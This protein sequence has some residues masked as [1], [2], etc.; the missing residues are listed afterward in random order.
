MTNESR[1]LVLKQDILDGLKTL[2][3]TKGS[4]VMVHT[5]LKNMG[6][7]CGGAQ[8]VIESLLETVGPEGTIVMPTQTW[9]NLD[10]ETGVHW[11]EPKEW[12]PII[13]ENWPAYDKR[14]TPTNTMGKV[15]EMFRSWPGAYRSDHP[16]RSVAAVGKYANYITE[17]H[18]L[19][20]IF[21]EGSPL[22]KIYKLNGKV[23]LIG[24]GYDK[25]TSIHLADAKAE[26]ESKHNV[27]ESSAIMINGK[28]E[29]VTYETLFVDG[30]DFNEIGA[31][32]EKECKVN[33][34]NIGNALVR[35]MSQRE[36]VDYSVKWIEKNR[37]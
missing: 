34:T 13:R 15:A 18:D 25:N 9:K 11:E 3:V 22:D 6:F 16:A 7:V 24:V 29:W 36:L 17:N 35:Y 8:I 27:K 28:R 1:K 10:P 14:I 5:S 30:E 19:S 23:L 21:G 37:K 2:G 31:D 33:S 26:Y 20:N 32:F 4:I 12:W